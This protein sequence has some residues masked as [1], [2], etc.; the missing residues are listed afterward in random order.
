MVDQFTIIKKR[1]IAG[2]VCPECDVVDRIVVEVAVRAADQQEVFRRRCVDCSFAD[3]FG[4]ETPIGTQGVPRGRP[5][6]PKNTPVKPVQV[7]ILD[8]KEP[9]L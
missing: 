1:F 2:A 4:V 7:R 5:E 6:K 3:P 9:G 8:P